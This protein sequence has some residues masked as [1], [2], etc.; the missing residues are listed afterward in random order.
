MSFNFHKNLIQNIKLNK[1]E[2]VNN[3]LEK[4]KNENENFLALGLKQ[5]HLDLILSFMISD[6]DINTVN[7]IIKLYEKYNW[8]LDLSSYSLIIKF[9]CSIN[10][11]NEALSYLEK[12]ENIKNRLISPFFEKLEYLKKEIVIDLFYKYFNVMTE[13]EYYYLFLYFKNQY[14][15]D[16]MI[17]NKKERENNETVNNII[18]KIFNIWSENDI[19]INSELVELI[20]IWRK[21]NPV[22]IS[23]DG[24]CS[25]CNN[26]LVKHKLENKDKQ[27]LIKQLLIAHPE[28]KDNLLK[29][30]EFF[31]NT[32]DNI[33][34]ES[35]NYFNILDAG[36]I[37]HSINGEFSFKILE[38]F[39]KDMIKT[40]ELSIIF[41]VIH[42]K[43]YKKYKKE[44]TNLINMYSQTEGKQYNLVFYNTPY[45]ENDDLYWILASL[46]SE[47]KNTNIITNDL[48][49][50]H[51]VNKLDETLFQRWK[52][53]Y[54]STYIYNYHLNKPQ[55]NFPS[56]WTIGTQK[57]HIPVI[58]NNDTIKWYC[59]E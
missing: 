9:L 54:L 43:H 20:S 51:H 39:I 11:I 1:R 16:D 24:K 5:N 55:I 17:E 3:I 29:L 31:K 45:K 53:N 25:R 12:V 46:L 4:I 44:I 34:F 32:F 28:S 42:Q 2:E 59:L 58:D 27:K 38:L 7:I 15:S 30:I 52:K 35:I 21:M 49:R 6:N 41:V 37:C 36:N 8:K 33:D 22:I 26:L 10:H 18:N 13:K 23:E 47:C 19:I 57:N 40:Y 50:D 56:K 48:L 14:S